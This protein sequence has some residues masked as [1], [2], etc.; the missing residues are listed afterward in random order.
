MADK[1][2]MPV[3]ELIRETIPDP[4]T[5][6]RVGG[7]SLGERAYVGYYVACGGRSL[8]SGAELPSWDEQDEKIQVA[9]ECAADAVV[10]AL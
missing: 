7:P 2:F 8:I 3:E 1:P 6:S 10:G 9:W 4:D 5:Q